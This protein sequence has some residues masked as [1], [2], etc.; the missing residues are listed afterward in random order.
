MK[1]QTKI[2]F[3]TF[4]FLFYKVLKRNNVRVRHKDASATKRCLRN[5]NNTLAFENV[6]QM[7]LLKKY[8][9]LIFN[10]YSKHYFNFLF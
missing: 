3:V 4:C 2:S 5:T 1:E 6:L 8:F 10:F 9:T 7:G